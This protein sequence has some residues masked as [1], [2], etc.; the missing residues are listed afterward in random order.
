MQTGQDPACSEMLPNA[1]TEEHCLHL[2]LRR[3]CQA[4]LLGQTGP[5]RQ[6]RNLGRR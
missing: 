3:G 1:V 2:Q 6:L 4:L 5:R